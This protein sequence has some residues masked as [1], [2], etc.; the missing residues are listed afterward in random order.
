MDVFDAIKGRRSIRSYQD[1]PVDQEKIG[2]L[3]E[4]LRWAPSAGNRQPWEVIVVDDP[5]KIESLA[6]AALEQM[7][8]KTAPV[9]LAVCINEKIAKGTYGERSE[10]YALQTIGMATEN[11]MLAAHSIG[12]GTCCV[13]A[14]EDDKVRDI[15]DCM[16]FI[17]P[18][19]L[20]TVGYPKEEPPV[21]YREEI[22]EFTHYNSYQEK[23]MP[24]LPGASHR[25]GGL[26]KKLYDSLKNL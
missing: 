12:L 24:R 2:L 19:A 18:V 23:Y 3:L 14:F 17:K 16:E 7:W 10:Q 11:M 25:K 9:I 15:M 8:M 6:N 4:A 26:R 22:A 1:K 20:V 21:P 5:E 13:T